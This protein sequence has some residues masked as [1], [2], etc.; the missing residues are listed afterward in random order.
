MQLRIPGP[1][2]ASMRRR[3]SLLQ[4]WQ[5]AAS[6]IEGSRLYLL[7]PNIPLNMLDA[8]MLYC[9]ETLQLRRKLLSLRKPKGSFCSGTG[10]LQLYKVVPSMTETLLLQRGR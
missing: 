6:T 5:D 8:V 4:R 2:V 1:R 7:Y 3:G 10:R 9:N